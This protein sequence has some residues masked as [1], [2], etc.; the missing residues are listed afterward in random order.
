MPSN[1]IRMIAPPLAG[2]WKTAMIGPPGRN[3]LLIQP[4]RSAEA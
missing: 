1:P 2:Y 3:R 4:Q